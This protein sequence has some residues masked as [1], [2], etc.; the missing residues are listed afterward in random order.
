MNLVHGAD[1]VKLDDYFLIELSFVINCFLQM[2]P[3]NFIINEIMGL[4][5]LQNSLVE[6]GKVIAFTKGGV[7]EQKWKE[8]IMHWK[9]LCKH[10]NM[11][12][13]RS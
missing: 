1:S 6:P 11:E 9:E 13:N 12:I 5:R 10:M 2:H 8:Q 4:W 3:N 7:I